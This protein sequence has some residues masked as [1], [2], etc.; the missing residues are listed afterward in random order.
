MTVVA[1]LCGVFMACGI[2]LL[3]AEAAWRRLGGIAL[4]GAALALLAIAAGGQSV[5]ASRM[6]VALV[7][8]AFGLFLLYASIARLPE[9][10]TSDLDTP[11]D[12][13]SK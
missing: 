13:A 8:S 5:A 10:D 1:L 7:L 12:G 3:L 2:Y 9:Q 6:G 4:T 11:G